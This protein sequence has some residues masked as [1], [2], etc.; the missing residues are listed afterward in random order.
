[1]SRTGDY[2]NFSVEKA[3]GKVTDD[4]AIMLSLVNRKEYAIKHIVAFTDLF[5]FT[6]GNE[7]IISGSSTVTPTTVSPRYSPHGGAKILNLFW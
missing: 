2:Y 7:W 6:D 4:S 1:M 5:F 3:D